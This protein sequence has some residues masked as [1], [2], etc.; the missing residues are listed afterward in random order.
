[1]KNARFNILLIGSGRMAQ[2]LKHWNSLL[3]SPA[4]LLTWNRSEDVH[5][6]NERLQKIDLVWLAISDSAIVEFFE[7]HL[8]GKKVIH[9]SGALHDHRIPCAHPLMSF[10]KSLLESSV[11]PNI[12]FAVTGADRLQDL[13][14]NFANTF[15]VLAAENKALYHALCVVAGNFPQLLWQ[16]CF[17]EFQKLAIPEQAFNTYIRQITENFIQL[18]N[19]AITG[20]LVRRDFATI[21]KNKAALEDSK[22]QK[23]YSSF[24]KEFTP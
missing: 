5:L 20:P 2:H 23:V 4:S 3:Q 24:E 11:Y 21:E 9:F 15:S 14:P 8:Q 6:L 13:M 18:K 17:P 10:P 19:N 16:E 22:L 12:H 7:Q 1:M